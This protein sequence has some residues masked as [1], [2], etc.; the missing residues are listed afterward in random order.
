VETVSAYDAKTHLPRLL[1]RVQRGERFTITR[2]GVPIAVLQPLDETARS[3]PAETIA[4]LRD[5]RRGKRLD[6]LSLRELVEDGRR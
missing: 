5:F 1:R 4:E 2:H 3:D 6:G